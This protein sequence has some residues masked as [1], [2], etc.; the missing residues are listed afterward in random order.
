VSERP[1]E[2]KVTHLARKAVVYMRQSTEIQLRENV[3][4]TEAQRAQRRYAEAWGWFADRIEV[5]D[6][7]LGLT[8]TATDHRP[9][10]QRLV[11]DIDTGEV[12]AVLV[13]DE[14]RLGRDMLAK[15]QFANLCIAKN[16]LLILDGRVA[17]LADPTTLLQ[18]QLTA[19]FSQHENLRRAEHSRRGVEARLAAG[20]AVT[21]PPAG[22]V[23]TEKGVWELDPDPAVRE[24]FR[25]LVG[26]YLRERSYYRTVRALLDMGVKLPR[27]GRPI[28]FV[29]PTVN[30]IAAILTNPQYT[31]AYIYRRRTGD[32]G[33]GRGRNGAMLRRYATP[34]ETV[35]IPNH[36]P[37]F[38]TPE[39]WEEIQ[40]IRARNAPRRDRRN[41][42]PGRALAQGI[43]TCGR[44]DLAMATRYA[45]QRD[46]DDDPAFYYWCPG[47]RA[48]GGTECGSVSGRRIDR[49]VL[50]AVLAR[51]APPRVAVLADSIRELRRDVGGHQRL[52]QLELRRLQRDAEDLESHLLQVDPRNCLVAANLEA[53]LERTLRE[54][55]AAKLADER[56]QPSVAL[57]DADL[58]ELVALASDLPNLLSAPTTTH[59]DRKAIVRTLIQR[60]IIDERSPEALVVIVLWCDQIEDTVLRMPGDCY[61]QRQIAAFAAEGKSV[62][63]ISIRLTEEHLLT[64]WGTPWT[65]NAVGAALRRQRRGVRSRWVAEG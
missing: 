8:G 17:D 38:I 41:L 35:V 11:R 40:A 56:V 23:R 47:D 25:I 55:K 44:H 3:G 21:A 62:R 49:V 10:Y 51:L 59:H 36:H 60:V 65:P 34:D 13:S 63:E 37:P 31:G 43:V 29:K 54:L 61:T 58:A 64:S 6:D 32:P 28:R 16:V 1:R 9:G 24:P 20:K 42:G 48:F 7:D 4:S 5:I 26:T 45:R 33:R 19:A 57:A 52:R 39:E 12:G 50:D 53:K 27:R 2:I 30:I 22:Y 18:T 15:L 14:S 46:G